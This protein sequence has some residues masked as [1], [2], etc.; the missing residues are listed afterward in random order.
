MSGRSDLGMR[1]LSK[2]PKFSLRTGNYTGVNDPP[3]M[4]AVGV[5]DA[6]GVDTRGQE[7]LCDSCH[8]VGEIVEISTIFR[9]DSWALVNRHG[10]AGTAHKRSAEERISKKG[11]SG[12]GKA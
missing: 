4:G 1:N 2:K 10:M 3:L 11:C 6:L 5:S 7:I 12:H 8:A 9:W